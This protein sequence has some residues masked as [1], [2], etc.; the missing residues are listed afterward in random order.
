MATYLDT[1]FES[2]S[3]DAYFDGTIGTSA[4]VATN[5]VRTG[6]Y[7][8]EHDSSSTSSTTNI[9]V[10]R[11]TGS[12]INGSSGVDQLYFHF[13]AY[14]ESGFTWPANHLE[15]LRLKWGNST[16]KWLRFR[17]DT[18]GVI[19]E[20]FNNSPFKSGSDSAGTPTSFTTGSWIHFEFFAKMNTSGNSDGEYFWKADS[21][22]ILSATDVDFRGT[23]TGQQFD[24]FILM[25]QYSHSA[26]SSSTTKTHIDD[27]QVLDAEPAGA[28][29]TVPV[30]ANYY[31]RMRA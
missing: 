17:I 20:W 27:L 21:T 26:S 24:A 1:G 31:R 15:I 12:G 8:S 7:S 25:L 19:A 13:Y 5:Q 29:T 4:S 30:M 9:R 14:F 10:D 6:T 23:S 18:G 3:Y 22:T 16:D 11:A 2:G 28:S